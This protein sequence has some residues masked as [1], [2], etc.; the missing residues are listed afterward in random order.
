MFPGF[1]KHDVFQWKLERMSPE[2]AEMTEPGNQP[3]QYVT[4][5][6]LHSHNKWLH[7]LER[8]IHLVAVQKMN[9]KLIEKK[10]SGLTIR[11]GKKLHKYVIK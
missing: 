3:D 4:A 8:Q 6:L 11:P 2:C 1:Q 10:T 7:G 9:M 5:I